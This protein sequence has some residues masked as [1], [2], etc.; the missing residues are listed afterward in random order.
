MRNEKFSGIII[1]AIRDLFQYRHLIW[2]LAIK[3]IKVKYRSPMLG[4]LWAILVPLTMVFIYKF[5]FSKIIRAGFVENF[6]FFIYLM[7]AIFP[8][9]YFSSSINGATDCI[10]G[11]RELI[12]NTYFPRHIIPV[13]V[14]LASLINFVPAL[15]VMILLLAFFKMQFTILILLLPVILL[16]QTIF[17]IGLAFIVSS[18]QVVLRDVKYIVEVVL[19]AWLFL[20]PGFYSLVMVTD[21]SERFFKFY[22]LNPFVGLFSLYRIALLKGFSDTLPPGM[23]IYMLSVWITVVSVAT[24]LFGLLIFKRYEPRFPD[25]I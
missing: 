21:I 23:N 15:I 17:S 12:K 8:W 13:S 5:V 24:F 14:V 16:V 10:F 7:T 20:S 18:L 25:L 2:E 3:D 22:M 9:T 6:P 4:F 1:K 11:N 19:M